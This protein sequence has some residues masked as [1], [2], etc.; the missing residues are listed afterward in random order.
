MSRWDW[1]AIERA[2]LMP[3]KQD[4]IRA[5]IDLA[6]QGRDKTAAALAQ[7]Q[8]FQCDEGSPQELERLRGVERMQAQLGDWCNDIDRLE[9]IV[10]EASVLG[11]IL[12]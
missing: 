4:A 1:E 7:G 12:A 8:S 2:A 3:E 5:L 11:R 9:R 6:Y 10:R